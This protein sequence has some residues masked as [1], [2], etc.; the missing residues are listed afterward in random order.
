MKK[1]IIFFMIAAMAAASFTGCG[2]ETAAEPKEEILTLPVPGGSA[3]DSSH[4]ANND[5][6]AETSVENVPDVPE[7]T[8]VAP[9]DGTTV[10]LPNE[11]PVIPPEETVPATP[12]GNGTETP[13]VQE[14]QS[15]EVEEPQSTAPQESEN[16]PADG[17]T[18]PEVVPPEVQIPETP[19]PVTPEIPEVAPSE[20]EQPTLTTIQK[21]KT[22]NKPATYTGDKYL[23]LVNPWNYLPADFER[24]TK[25]I[26]GHYIDVGAYD[27]IVQM[28]ADMRKEGLK[29]YICSSTRTIE[30]QE[31]L[32][33]KRLNQNKAKGLS[34]QEAL[35]E[36]AKWTAIP[37]TSEHHTGY[38]LDIVA[39]YNTTL[40]ES[41]ENTKEQQWMMKN[42]WK[43]GF[44]LRYPKD[45]THI[46]GIYYEPWHY[47]YVGK[48]AAKEIYESGL[49]LEEY[50]GK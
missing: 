19:A 21:Q 20:N 47:R 23:L 36:T 13:E 9:S 38:A 25:K 40:D 15:P 26:E 43:Y 2:G 33:N 24:N 17:Q 32:F 12:A 31:N 29:P 10:T 18:E 48:T 11:T 45:K 8:P 41:Q 1:M 34:E 22:I 46:T 30:Y 28:L 14:P 35:D 16:T 42:S 37:G 3:S 50:L 7:V 6:G 39:T 27:D 5:A 49:T 44:I 4:D